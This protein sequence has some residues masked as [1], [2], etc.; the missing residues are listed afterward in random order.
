[1]AGENQITGIL[2]KYG[3]E[4]SAELK[5]MIQRKPVTKY[6]VV[7]ASGKLKDSVHYD[8]NGNVMR[9][10]ALDYV[11]YLEKGRG[12]TKKKGEKPLKEIIYE[13]IETKPAAQSRFNWGALKEYQRKSIAYLIARKIHEEGTTIYQQGGSTL[14]ADILSD[15]LKGNIQGDLILTFREKTN[16]LMR[17]AITGK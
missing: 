15:T 8:I 11:Y 13:W 4:I 10:Y 2:N 14:V 12:P 1:M 3:A 6:G 17:S 7:N 9:V 16:A 5:D